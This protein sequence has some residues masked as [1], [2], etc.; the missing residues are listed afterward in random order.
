MPSRADDGAT[1]ADDDILA[2]AIQRY[3]NLGVAEADHGI[4]I[5]AVVV[6]DFMTNDGRSVSTWRIPD[7]EGCPVWD[8][9]G[10][11]GYA[12]DECMREDA[13]EDE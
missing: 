8:A 9:S 2:D 3:A 7:D 4:L 10:L 1:V 5:K 12:L 11:I 6:A 13:E